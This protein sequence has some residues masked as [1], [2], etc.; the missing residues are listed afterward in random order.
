M[1]FTAPEL[2]LIGAVAGVG[3]L[4]TVVPDHWLPITL[5]AR[6]RGWS[7]A[8]TARA[9]FGAGLGHVASTLAIAMVVWIAGVVVARQFGQLVNAAASAAL[10]AFGAWIA[11]SALLEMRRSHG[12][13]HSHAHGDG[14]HH[15]HGSG[16][17]SGS[18]TALLL[19]LGSSPMVEGIPAFFAAGR[20]GFG[21]IL[22]M[23]AVFAAA[24][25]ATY[26]VL[27][28]GSVA[29]L[30]RF[31]LRPLER[32]GEVLSG[33]FIAGVGLLFWLLGPA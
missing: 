15:P 4:H 19:I 8:E 12:H 22:A 16:R 30:Q 9:A 31:R 32:Y 23:S 26:V 11:I 17:N 21:L 2:L 18:S 7:S 20:Y 14:H 25:M 33:A 28:V 27:C 29:G 6:Q 1:I 5:I 10:V 24:T 3:V 13:G